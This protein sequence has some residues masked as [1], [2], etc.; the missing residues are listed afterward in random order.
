MTETHT[1]TDTIV[2]CSAALLHGLCSYHAWFGEAAFAQAESLRSPLQNFHFPPF[3]QATERV[4]CPRR[5]HAF[6]IA[7][8]AVG[9]V[10]MACVASFTMPAS[11]KRSALLQEYVMIPVDAQM[12]Q[13]RQMFAQR[14][15]L[16]Q[17]DPCADHTDPAKLACC[18]ECQ[19]QVG[20]PGGM[21]T[22]CVPVCEGWMDPSRNRFVNYF[23]SAVSPAASCPAGLM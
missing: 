9:L 22:I 19:A 8:A 3:Q 14:Q 4:P 18:N 11:I 21:H 5:R 15:Q 2:V 12:M 10:A 13:E 7:L 17:G 16:T 23:C 6:A 1:D 20:G